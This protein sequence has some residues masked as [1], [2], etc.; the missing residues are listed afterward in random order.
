MCGARNRRRGGGSSRFG[1]VT[2]V[3]HSADIARG[4]LAGHVLD[5]RTGDTY[6][7]VTVELLR[8]YGVTVELR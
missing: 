2:L 5:H 1:T 6:F 8:K 7:D 3:W 4:P